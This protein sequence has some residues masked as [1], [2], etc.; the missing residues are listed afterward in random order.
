MPKLVQL[1]A[2]IWSL[3]TFVAIASFTVGGVWTDWLK[4]RDI[5]LV[6][7]IDWPQTAGEREIVVSSGDTSF[8][9]QLDGVQEYRC[10]ENQVLIGVYSKHFGSHEDRAF[11][12]TCGVLS[13]E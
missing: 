7:D 1:F 6:P 3:V 11:T 9:S 8:P 12:F 5:V 2:A 13:L 10:P 4:V